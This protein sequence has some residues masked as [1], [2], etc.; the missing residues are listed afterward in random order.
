[1]KTILSLFLVLALTS[2]KGQVYA[3]SET[4]FVNGL[5]SG[6]SITAPQ[7][8]AD[9]STSSYSTLNL[10]VDTIGAYVQ[11]NLIFSTSAGSNEFAGVIVEDVNLGAL[12]ASLLAGT[13]LTTF[14]NNVSNNDT[15]SSTQFTIAL[16]SG[17]TSKYKLEFQASS[18]FDAVELKFNAGIAG[19]LDSLNIYY[20]YHSMTVLPIRLVDFSASVENDKVKLNWIT[21][22][23]TNNKF[24]TV[25]E[26]TDGITFHEKG[27]INSSGNSSSLKNYEFVDV[28]SQSGILYYRLKQTDITEV[29][30]YSKIVSVNY[31]GQK[32]GFNIFPNPS[33]GNF[34]L[35]F[36][37]RSEEE[38]GEFLIYNFMGQKVITYSL[39]PGTDHLLIEKSNLDKGIY[40]VFYRTNDK[41][42]KHSKLIIN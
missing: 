31:E 35:K 12:D 36:G 23:E 28:P 11:Q 13:T 21:A 15:H 41:I 17:S 42:A 24:F 34:T 4:N 5:C 1:M 16:L 29:H 6:C 37:M 22:T 19:S 26:S 38:A 25:E 14:S 27:K 40:D 18:S 3:D 7:N 33:G 2:A 32:E 9:G 39:A 8:S 30:Q 10:A 20:A